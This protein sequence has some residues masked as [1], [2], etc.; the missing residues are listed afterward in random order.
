MSSK[1][2]IKIEDLK[3][4]LSKAADQDYFKKME[5]SIL[6]N[7]VQKEELK[8]NLKQELVISKVNTQPLFDV[9]VNYFTKLENAIASRTYDLEAEPEFIKI[10]ESKF[11][12]QNVFSV[13][14]GYFDWLP[15]RASDR[16]R[17]IV[18]ESQNSWEWS[19]QKGRASLYA[20]AASIVLVCSIT[21]YFYRTNENV[22]FNAGNALKEI[23]T[24]E[25]LA[26]MNSVEI[27]ADD[28]QPDK[29]DEIHLSDKANLH[30]EL[31]NIDYQD[32]VD[33]DEL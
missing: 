8:L 17:I 27:D 12:R 16:K 24:N 32:I 18:P 3:Q 15:Q 9:P 23:S 2:N 1:K 5:V 21:M 4:H 10:F 14:E 31:E 13:P 22:Q 20:I 26:Y 28:I 7:T 29:F 11:S 25:V 6:K 33:I 30:K 19:L